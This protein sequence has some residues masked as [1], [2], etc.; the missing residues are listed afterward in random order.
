MKIDKLK[1]LLQSKKKVTRIEIN[2]IV[3]ST[4]ATWLIQSLESSWYIFK[5]EYNE[6]NN[7]LTYELLEYRKPFRL[8]M[9]D[10]ELNHPELEAQIRILYNNQNKLWNI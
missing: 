3:G 8:I 1:E 4:I 2:E 6:F 5:I 10:I 7:P 9:R